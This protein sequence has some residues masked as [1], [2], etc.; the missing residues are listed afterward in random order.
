VRAAGCQGWPVSY[1]PTAAAAGW[2]PLPLGDIRHWHR[3][4]GSKWA[5]FDYVW[6]LCAGCLA[7]CW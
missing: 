3:L 7:M 6:M 1:L 4:L 2:W 5:A